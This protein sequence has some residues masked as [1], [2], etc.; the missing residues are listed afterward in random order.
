MTVTIG[1]LVSAASNVEVNRED[2]ERIQQTGGNFV[3]RMFLGVDEAGA[4]EL[5]TAGLK[6][7]DEHFDGDFDVAMDF[8]KQNGGPG[9]DLENRTVGSFANDPNLGA[10]IDA[11]LGRPAAPAEAV[12]DVAV[13][14]EDTTKEELA[15]QEETERRTRLF[16][17][18]NNESFGDA[19]KTGDFGQIFKMIIEAL[20]GESFAL[21]NKPEEF[22]GVTTPDGQAIAANKTQIDP[23]NG[24]QRQDANTLNTNAQ[25]AENEQGVNV[26]L[27]DGT[28]APR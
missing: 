28:L 13:P 24:Q 15:A 18:F 1:K 6:I 20:T 12:A 26:A 25:E 9:G 21:G 7:A 10:Y 17:L 27:V 14:G 5:A 2:L 22:D 4:K 11:K 3:E 19:F 8:L 16:S 23:E